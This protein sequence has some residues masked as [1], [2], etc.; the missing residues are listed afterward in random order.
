MNGDRRDLLPV[1]RLKNTCDTCATSKIKCSKEKP[2][3]HRCTMLGCPCN[4]SPA[5]RLG[6]P[7]PV[8]EKSPKN[9]A[10]PVSGSGGQKHANQSRSQNSGAKSSIA[11]DKA[12][13]LH[14]DD[15]RQRPI[16]KLE[17]SAHQVSDEV[18]F[19]VY[20]PAL[21]QNRQ[22][23]VLRADQC[24]S[25]EAKH[26]NR[27]HYTGNMDIFD[28][29]DRLDGANL[30]EVNETYSLPL[31]NNDFSKSF[32]DIVNHSAGGSTRVDHLSEVLAFAESS[33][34]DAS[35][36][37]CALAAINLL[38]DLNMKN[39]R[40]SGNA[41]GPDGSGM[42]T[43]DALIHTTSTTMK[44]VSDILACSCSKK[45]DVGLLVAAI[46]AA[47]LDIYG[48]LLRDSSSDNRQKQASV[49]PAYEMMGE[50]DLTKLCAHG[51]LDRPSK[52]EISMQILGRLLDMANLV[53]QFSQRCSQDG[54]GSSPDLL[55]SLIGSLRC[56]LKC[57]SNEATKRLASV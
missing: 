11:K 41:T 51:S 19:D 49:F 33:D 2:R 46:C 55:A 5:R 45:V 10:V 12:Q 13:S 50:A 24:F 23:N 56:R 39:T 3:C 31:P 57:M 36:H 16:K 26:T 29:N 44:G 4:Y 37:D 40:R 34:S 47:I 35:E 48:I 1:Q 8:R 6:R 22:S 32:S 52:E 28:I 42:L 9:K 15:F 43:I 17:R 14:D 53:A 21:S 25:P 20:D 30:S 38:Q 7:N 54:G 27:F 18:G